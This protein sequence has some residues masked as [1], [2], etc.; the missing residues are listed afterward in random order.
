MIAELDHLWSERRSR[1]AFHPEPL[2]RAIL[3]Q[4]FS[5]AQYAP[6]WCNTQPWRVVITEP[7]PPFVFGP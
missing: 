6:S 4:I 5:A 1:R 7:L 2:D 3:D